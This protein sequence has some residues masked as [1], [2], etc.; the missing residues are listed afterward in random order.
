VPWPVYSERFVATTAPNTWFYFTV[1]PG[2]RAIVKCIVVIGLG[3]GV[4]IGYSSIG[5]AYGLVQ[6]DPGV[7]KTLIFN[8]HQVAYAGEQIGAMRTTDNLSVAV[9]GFLLDDSVIRSRA[10][11]VEEGEPPP[12]YLAELA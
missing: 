2:R 5:P 9:H 8:C 12:F 10:P 6:A 7:N 3:S 11:R 4:G 1:P